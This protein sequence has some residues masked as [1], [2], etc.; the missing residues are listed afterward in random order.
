VSSGR[1]LAAHESLKRLESGLSTHSTGTWAVCLVEGSSYGYRRAATQEA[2]PFWAPATRRHPAMAGGCASSGAPVQRRLAAEGSKVVEGDERELHV[3]G[4]MKHWRCMQVHCRARRSPW[5]SKAPHPTLL[6]IAVPC[7]LSSPSPRPRPR[8]RPR[9]R[10]RSV[11]APIPRRRR[12]R[13]RAALPHSC[14]RW[15]G[16]CS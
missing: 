12:R 13:R 6:P 4:T 15:T 3:T 16:P 1:R 14:A 9:L 11:C 10:S 2:M 5:A 8:P 7:R